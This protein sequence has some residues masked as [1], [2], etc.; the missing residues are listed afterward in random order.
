MQNKRN[1]F[2]TPDKCLGTPERDAT[3]CPDDP[4]CYAHSINQHRRMM[5]LPDAP[6]NVETDTVE[7]SLE[8]IADALTAISEHL[9]RTL[10]RS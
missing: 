7:E 3:R 10:H 9:N 4:E 1:A 8:R 5:G 6:N 2:S